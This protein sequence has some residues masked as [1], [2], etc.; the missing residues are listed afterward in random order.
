MTYRKLAL[1]TLALAVLLPLA[2]SAEPGG[3]RH[4]GSGR[5]L[6]PPPG[7]LDLSEEQVEATQALREAVR[8]DVQAQREQTRAL[9]DQLEAALANGSPDATEV[10]QLVIELHQQKEA[11]RSA[12]ESIESQFTALLT[13]EQLEKWE[14][15]KELRGNR[16]HQRRERAFGEGFR[17]APDPSR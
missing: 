4:R 8:E 15:F 1:F 13:E 9:R 7:Y 2:A 12:R 6:L 5:G 14:N 3:D 10:G 17:Q 16:R 11:R